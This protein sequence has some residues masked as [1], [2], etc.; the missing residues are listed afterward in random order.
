[1]IQSQEYTVKLAQGQSTSITALESADTGHTYNIHT[2]ILLGSHNDEVEFVLN[3]LTLKLG[4]GFIYNQTPIRSISITTGANG[5]LLIGRKT[6][7]TLF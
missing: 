2:V 7:K 1:M 6:K 5:A 4:G 3:G